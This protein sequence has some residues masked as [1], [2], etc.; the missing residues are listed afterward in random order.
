MSRAR[1]RF[2]TPP[3]SPPSSP[4]PTWDSSPPSSPVLDYLDL[5]VSESSLS[6]SH[7]VIDPLAASYNAN[8][9]KRNS[10]S[11]LFTP[12]RKTARYTSN[13]A[14]LTRQPTTINRRSQA[15]E[16]EYKIWEEV[17]N[18]VFESGCRTID[19]RCLINSLFMSHDPSLLKFNSTVTAR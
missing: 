4:S 17:S 11:L 15:D 16:R 2:C 5:S 3:S 8:C 14:P 7:R 9:D 19:L 10:S 12:Q 18:K 6:P 13:Q 1:N